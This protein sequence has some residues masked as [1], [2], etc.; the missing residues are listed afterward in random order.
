MQTQGIGSAVKALK[1][2]GMDQRDIPGYSEMDS[3]A[4]AK[5]LSVILGYEVS[6]VAQLPTYGNSRKQTSEDQAF[7]SMKG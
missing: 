5:A 2:K 7:R 3:E 1:A 6:A 4:R